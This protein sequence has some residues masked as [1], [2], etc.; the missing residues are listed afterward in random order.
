MPSPEINLSTDKEGAFISLSITE[1]RVLSDGFI[2]TTYTRSGKNI[3][4]DVRD[5]GEQKPSLLEKD[6]GYDVYRKA[7]EA[8]ID[9]SKK[10]LVV[11][12]QP[13]SHDQMKFTLIKSAEKDGFEFSSL[14][15]FENISKAMKNPKFV[16][17]LNAA[18]Q[19]KSI[20]Q[21]EAKL[22]TDV[23][24]DGAIDKNEIQQLNSFLK[25]KEQEKAT[26]RR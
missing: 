25:V 10:D 13:V 1:E 9:E 5:V 19:D 14:R 11:N 23:S 22:L 2:K 16:E 17:A 12:G 24:R 18:Y 7:A 26:N 21:S 15:G 8:L 3:Q 20:S 6:M 4:M